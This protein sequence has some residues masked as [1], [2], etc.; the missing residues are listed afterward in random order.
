MC[1]SVAANPRWNSP[2]FKSSV[3]TCDWWLP[4][5]TGLLGRIEEMRDVIT[6]ASNEIRDRV[7]W[8]GWNSTELESSEMGRSVRSSVNQGTP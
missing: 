7:L 8:D 1:L 2:R 5:G 3:A 6:V 4:Y